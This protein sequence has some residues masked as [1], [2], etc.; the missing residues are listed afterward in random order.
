MCEVLSENCSLTCFCSA[1]HSTEV[2]APE[3]PCADGHSTSVQAPQ[4]PCCRYSTEFMALF[5]AV[6]STSLYSQFLFSFSDVG[7]IIVGSATLRSKNCYSDLENS[8]NL[9]FGASLA[10]FISLNLPS[11]VLEWLFFVYDFLKI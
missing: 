8:L 11:K 4:V 5:S 1:G 2:L 10:A 7:A 6:K 3:E 9:A